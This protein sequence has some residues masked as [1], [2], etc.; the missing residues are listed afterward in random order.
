MTAYI[1]NS[2]FKYRKSA[3]LRALTIDSVN[4]QLI[5]VIPATYGLMHKQLNRHTKFPLR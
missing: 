4:G 2:S 3:L 5:L 1:I